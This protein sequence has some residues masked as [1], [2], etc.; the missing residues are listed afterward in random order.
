MAA[1]GHGG[2]DNGRSSGSSGSSAWPFGIGR[3]SGCRLRL[4]LP[5]VGLLE[6]DI[7]GMGRQ[8]LPGPFDAGCSSGS[9]N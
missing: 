4:G 7:L 2:V 1:D 9:I 6:V 5:K 8:R 3:S